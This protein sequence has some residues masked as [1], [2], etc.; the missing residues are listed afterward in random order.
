MSHMG[1]LRIELDEYE[2]G[3]LG[4]DDELDLFSKLVKSGMV[5]SLPVDYSIAASRI[6]EMGLMTGDGDLTV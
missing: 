1:E 6:I 3:R 4:V 2:A 5:H